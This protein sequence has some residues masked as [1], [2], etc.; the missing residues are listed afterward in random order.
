[1]V[2][3]T[4][5]GHFLGPAADAGFCGAVDAEKLADRTA[6][7]CADVALRDGGIHRCLGG[8]IAHWRIG[9]AVG[10]ADAQVKKDGRGDNRDAHDAGIK[11]DAALFAPAHHARGGVQPEGAAAGQHQ[12][13]DAFDQVAWPQRLQL[14]LADGSAAD[15]AR[16]HHA[17]LGKKHRAAGQR[18][19]ILHVA[20]LESRNWSE[21]RRH[22]RIVAE[23]SVISPQLSVQT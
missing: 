20:D 8:G 11:A 9:P 1:M 19:E 22:G 3:A 6:R 2:R 14:A 13:V 17:G 4:L 10:V 16:P 7:S 12:R 15:V 18:D 5:R 23:L 21:S